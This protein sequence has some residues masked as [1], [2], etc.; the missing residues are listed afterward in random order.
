MGQDEDLDLGCGIDFGFDQDFDPCLCPDFA[1]TETG[2]EGDGDIGVLE[3]MELDLPLHLSFL[4]EPSK[5]HS[6][7]VHASS[8]LEP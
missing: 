3:K 5:R 4:L 2:I 6:E 8:D 1:G 7:D